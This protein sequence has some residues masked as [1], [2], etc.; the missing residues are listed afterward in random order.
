M[1]SALSD[2]MASMLKLISLLVPAL[3]FF[4]LEDTASHQP[5]RREIQY[6]MGTNMQELKVNSG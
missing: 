3:A 6:R 1:Q 4:T 5:L 2:N